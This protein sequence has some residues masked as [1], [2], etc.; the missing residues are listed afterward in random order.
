MDPIGFGF[1][2]YDGMG[3][4]RDTDNSLP[5]DA[6]GELVAT[7]V[8]G[9]FNGAI[10]LGQK[11]SESSDV[12][13]CFVGGWLTFAYGR[14]ETEADACTRQALETAFEQSGGKVPDLL[15]A[16][17]QTDAFLYQPLR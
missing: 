1:E 14:A 8:A 4:W 9:P 6:S 11:L 17:T 13:S 12:R 2:N 3:Q 16:L 7:D 15:L 10:E 5:V